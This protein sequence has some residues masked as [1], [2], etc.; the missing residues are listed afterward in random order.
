MRIQDVY[1]KT[2]IKIGK[3]PIQAW[4]QIRDP[5][6]RLLTDMFDDIANEI[7]A[8]DDWPQLRKRAFLTQDLYLGDFDLNDA[9]VQPNQ[10][11]DALYSKFRYPEDYLRPVKSGTVMMN[12]D[13]YIVTIPITTL[14]DW[15]YV[16]DFGY[17]YPE[18]FILDPF[19]RTISIAPAFQF[20]NNEPQERIRLL[21]IQ[22][23]W[24][25]HPDGRLASQMPDSGDYEV[26]IDWEALHFGTTAT[27]FAHK[28][29]QDPYY[30][31]QYVKKRSQKYRDAIPSKIISIGMGTTDNYTYNPNVIP[32]SQMRFN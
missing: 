12:E 8:D 24:L 7:I 29:W 31:D 18:K 4:S 23:N 14:E 26:M 21:Y 11:E 19:E 13:D 25:K 1:N 27:F 5:N 10:G 15:F 3:K 28:K 30:S 16:T 17:S 32:R 6:Y 20:V 22:K 9:Q 2:C